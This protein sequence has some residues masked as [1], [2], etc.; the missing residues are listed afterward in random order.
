MKFLIIGLCLL[1]SGC[2]THQ[3]VKCIEVQKS[4][5]K[6][7]VVMEAARINALIEMTKSADPAVKATAIMQLQRNDVKTVTMNCPN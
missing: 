1:V 5:S 4:I 2:S 3:Y 6:D 7:M